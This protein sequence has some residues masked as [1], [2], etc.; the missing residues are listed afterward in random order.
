MQRLALIVLFFFPYKIKA[1]QLYSVHVVN[2]FSFMVTFTIGLKGSAMDS[3][4]AGCGPCAV[5]CTGLV[6][7]H[8]GSFNGV[9]EPRP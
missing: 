8:Q 7:P 4:K 1:S 9:S 6:G 3:Q 2:A 5:K